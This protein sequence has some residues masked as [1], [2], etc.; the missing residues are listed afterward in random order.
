M[1]TG[2]RPESL[3]EVASLSCS[4]SA[5]GLHLADFEHALLAMGS[6]KALAGAI[7]DRPPIRAGVFPS[8]ALADAWLASYAEEIAARFDLPFP[9]WIWAPERF[10]DQPYIH[11]GHSPTLKVWHT[12]KSPPSFTRRNLFVDFHFPPVR[13][14]SGRP[15]KSTEHKREMNRLRVARYRTRKRGGKRSSKKGDLR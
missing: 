1:K 13:L 15:R 6:R 3:A 8:G 4:Q 14:R 11:D 7:A 9:P 2:K 12:L 10:L 5:F